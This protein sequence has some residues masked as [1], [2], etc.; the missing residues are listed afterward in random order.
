MA[1]PTAR[2]LV[3]DIGISRSYAHDI[4]SGKQPPSRPLAIHIW[5]LFGWKAPI[6]AGHTDEEI[7]VLERA[8]EVAGTLP[9]VSAKAA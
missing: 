7:E 6:I 4:V 8:E 1:T 9:W 5:R 2:Q 3:E